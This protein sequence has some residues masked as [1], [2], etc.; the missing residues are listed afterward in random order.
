LTFNSIV[1]SGLKHV[2][3]GQNKNNSSSNVIH[4]QCFWGH[5][6]P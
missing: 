6:E 3:I 1:A 2:A 4:N 5:L